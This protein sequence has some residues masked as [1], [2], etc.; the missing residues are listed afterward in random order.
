MMTLLD[1]NGACP[2]QSCMQCLLPLQ[3]QPLF[4]IVINLIIKFYEINLFIFLNLTVLF[5]LNGVYQGLDQPEFMS[6][7]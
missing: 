1:I 5:D 2:T 3:F 6:D 7:Q 4:E